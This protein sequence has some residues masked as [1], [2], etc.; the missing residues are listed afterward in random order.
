VHSFCQNATP[1][2][3]SKGDETY[4]GRY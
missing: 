4:D 3:A 1:H 2:T